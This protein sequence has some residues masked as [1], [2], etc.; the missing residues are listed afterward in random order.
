MSNQKSQWKNLGCVETP[1]ENGQNKGK[2]NTLEMEQQ[3]V[4]SMT[5]NH[6]MK[7]PS[8]KQRKN[9]STLESPPIN[10]KKILNVK[11]R[12]LKKNTQRTRSLRK[13]P[14]GSILKERRLQGYWT[15]QSR[16]WLR[17]LWLPTGTG[18]VGSH[19]NT[20][21]GCLTDWELIS[22]LKINK[23]TV[24]NRNCPK[25]SLPLSTFSLAGTTVLEGEKEINKH[26]LARQKTLQK[27]E[28]LRNAKREKQNI[29]TVRNKITLT[30]KDK[31]IPSSKS[32]LLLPTSSQ[33]KPI[34]DWIASVRKVWNMG[35]HSVE[36][37]ETDLSEDKLRN[38]FVI[39]KNM[40][41]DNESRL[42]WTFRTP[43]RVREYAIK[44]LV[45][46]YKSGFTRLKKKQISRFR[47]TPKDKTQSKQ[48][49][50]ISHEMATIKDNYLCMSGMKIL[51]KETPGIVDI[52]NNMRL[53]RIEGNYFIHIPTFQEVKEIKDITDQDRL[54]SID[55]G[56]NI[57]FTYYCPDGE[58]GE[59]GLGM[60]EKLNQSYKKEE[61][62]QKRLKNKLRV[63]KAIQKLR[64]QKLNMVNDF[65]WKTV[66]WL[67]GR[68]KTIL[69]PRL[70]VA[71]TTKQVKHYQTDIRQC[72][73]VDRLTY[74]SME[75]KERI[76]H[77]VKEHGTSSLCT[78]CMS[79]VTTKSSVLGCSN[80]GLVI[81]R[82][83]G[84]ARNI[85]IK[86]LT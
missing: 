61:Q 19:G 73:F 16:D 51:M 48:T 17:K 37:K 5:L 55:P 52:S 79:L 49:I 7:T 34:N 18:Y 76:I 23:N 53:S 3:D 21:L 2:Y 43:K 30:T 22:S 9:T 68:Y 78:Q 39:R 25:I 80:C 56:I 84:A 58:W 1:L 11:S 86:H 83:L 29:P 75:Y 47:I 41:K 14:Q 65:Q 40:S 35:L 12:T 26:L 71:N 45:S 60:K 28:N 20:S 10:K 44:D 82:D 70:Y 42:E 36:T 57:P 64:L 50:C 13:L 63:K 31:I 32:I 8:P 4:A 27:Q 69:I 6:S 77:I 72:Q 46:C 74:K 59:I 15:K 38:K 24:T 85:L 54:I 81:H 67:L 62:I 66:H 33:K